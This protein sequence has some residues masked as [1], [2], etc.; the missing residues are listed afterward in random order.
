MLTVVRI[1]GPSRHDREL[2]AGIL[3]SLI[4]ETGITCEVVGNDVDLPDRPNWKNVLKS[5]FK[6]KL[7]PIVI[8]DS[9]GGIPI[10]SRLKAALRAAR[11]ANRKL[12]KKNQQLEGKLAECAKASSGARQYQFGWEARGRAEQAAAQQA[13]NSAEK[14][15]ETKLAAY[16]HATRQELRR[17]RSEAAIAT[18]YMVLHMVDGHPRP[19]VVQSY[20]N[21]SIEEICAACQISL[22]TTNPDELRWTPMVA[23]VIPTKT[24]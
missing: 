12:A 3:R 10:P 14:E 6:S 1:T 22:T 11:D 7:L 19:Y 16:K 13:R 4:R 20:H 2:L 9:A 24:T 21:P 18:P 15:F 5:M 23:P 17:A 8:G